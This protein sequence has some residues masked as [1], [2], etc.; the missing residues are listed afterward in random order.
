MS[1]FTFAERTC[2]DCGAVFDGLA[3]WD[4]CGPCVDA[5]AKERMARASAGRSYTINY[6]GG[7]CPTQA[8][9][10]TADGHH[11][12]FR[13]RH[14]QW[15]LQV[16][17]QPGADPL[18]APHRASGHDDTYGWMEDDAVLAILDAHLGDSHKRARRPATRSEPRQ[19]AV[20]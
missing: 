18:D 11:Y 10:V 1:V 9:G 8:E 20:R 13:A 16:A 6:I 12:Y 17:T 7:A 2:I 19:E 15:T 14:G 3:T 4:A 5:R